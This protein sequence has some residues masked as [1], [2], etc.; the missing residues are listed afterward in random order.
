MC[1]N[2]TFSKFH[3]LLISAFETISKCLSPNCDF[4][5]PDEY[6]ILEFR[7]QDFL[8]L[9]WAQGVCVLETYTFSKKYT[10][11]LDVSGRSIQLVP[12]YFAILLLDTLYKGF[13]CSLKKVLGIDSEFCNVEAIVTGLVDNYPQTL[14]KH[15]KLFT[16]GLCAFMFILGL[17]MCTNVSIELCI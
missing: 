14:L 1:S 17:P 3:K 16:V 11:G 5:F 12:T 8:D 4:F 6:Y 7:N 15:R 9:K 2:F 10:S 13:L